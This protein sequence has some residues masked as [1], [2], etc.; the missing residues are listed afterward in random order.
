M[1]Y[2]QRT[3]YLKILSGCKCVRLFWVYICNCPP[4]VS[5]TQTWFQGT[6]VNFVKWQWRTGVWVPFC[7]W[8]K[9]HD[10][11][12]FRGGVGLFQ[13]TDYSLSLRQVKAGKGMETWSRNHR[14][15]YSPAAHRLMLHWLS[16]QSGSNSPGSGAAHSGL[17]DSVSVNRRNHFPQTSL[18]L[19]VLQSWLLFQMTLAHDKQLQLT[20]TNGVGCGRSDSVGWEEGSV[21]KALTSLSWKQE[22]QT[23]FTA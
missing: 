4:L 15:H 13:L 22:D 6:C 17:E 23:E 21:C 9:Y 1:L 8:D 7:L 14:E 5:G 19:A 11:R 2:A 20:R 10:Q 3:C 16:Y 18:I 12:Q